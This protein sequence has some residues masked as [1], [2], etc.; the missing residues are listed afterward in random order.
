MEIAPY[1]YPEFGYN[2]HD[3]IKFLEQMRYNFF[4]ENLREIDSIYKHVNAIQDGSTQNLFLLKD[5]N[6]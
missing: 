3:L 2:C 5:L 1:L 4:D 6:I